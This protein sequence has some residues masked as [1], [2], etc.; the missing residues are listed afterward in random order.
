[1]FYRRTFVGLFIPVLHTQNNGNLLKTRE[2][3]KE[4]E[5]DK[6]KKKKKRKKG[7]KDVQWKRYIQ[8]A[9]SAEAL[10]SAPVYPGCSILPSTKFKQLH[11][12]LR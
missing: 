1:M 10:V 9:A 6:Q 11:V 5:R 8:N 2:R 12:I 7:K 3:E 4:S